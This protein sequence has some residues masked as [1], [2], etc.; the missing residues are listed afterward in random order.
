MF[1]GPVLVTFILA[2][3]SKR[4]NHIGMNFGIITA[5]LINLVF[6]NTMQEIFNYDIG[7]KIFWIWLNFTGVVISLFVAYLVS[8]ITPGIKAKQAKMIEFK[9]KKSDIFSKE[10]YIL[11]AFFIFILIFSYFLPDIYG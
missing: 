8:A 6:S 10:V 4:V 7:I 11:V 1:Y 2:I 5:V 9:V 3:F